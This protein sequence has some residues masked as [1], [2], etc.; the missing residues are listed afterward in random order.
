M[1]NSSQLL[2]TTGLLLAATCSLVPASANES[3]SRFRGPSASGLA[4]QASIPESW[5]DNENVAWKIELPGRGSSS[6]VYRD[7][8]IFLTAFTGYGLEVG[9]EGKLADL[10]L[11]TLCID[12][13]SGKVLWDES[14]PASPAEQE[15]TPRIVDHGYASPTPCVDDEAVYASFGPSG[16]IAY[17]LDGKKLWQRST[18][19]RTE[20][21]G[22]ASSPIL[23]QD[24][25]IINASIEDQAVYGLDKHTGE[26][27]WRTEGILKAWTTP[28]LVELKD[29]STEM[30]LN[31][32]DWILGLDP[33]TGNELWRCQG[34]EDYVVPCVVSDGEIAYC[35]GGRQNR[36]IA[37]RLG[38]RGDV[39][40][41]HKVWESVVGA[42]VT[43]P[44]LYQGNLYWS[45]DKSMAVCVRAK[46]GEEV[47][48]KRLPTSARVYASIV[49]AGDRLLMTTRD[50]GVLTL[51]A[52]PEYR[53]LGIFQLG[54]PEESFN[55]T[56]AITEDSLLLRSDRHL[57]RIAKQ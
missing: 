47:F 34:I 17:S 42:N 26:I 57:Y 55:A 56:P 52:S 5:G 18:G 12:Y 44:L 22:S 21:F 40:E 14:I 33:T 15:A 41:T 49:L 23:F 51:A 36:T 13:A 38:G 29:G 39:T 48:R 37:V 20:G 3:W 31:Q 4:P 25:V 8:K 43:S 50:A 45:H 35:S 27:R 30:V 32:K 24:M 46:D 6:P 19:K 10:R 11:H 9:V 2:Q 16:V 1:V 28:T 7:G 54:S 53:E